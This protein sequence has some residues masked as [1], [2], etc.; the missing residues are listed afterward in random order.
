M[1]VLVLPPSISFVPSIS[2]VS[3]LSSLIILLFLLLFLAFFYSVNG[4]QSFL[5][6]H[7]LL[8]FL[9]CLDHCL[10]GILCQGCHKISGLQPC[11]E[12]REMYLIICLVYF[13]HSSDETRYIRPQWFLLPLFD[14]EQVV[15]SPFWTLPAYEMKDKGTAQ[16]L[17][18][19]NG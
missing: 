10:G 12:G 6:V 15:G 18:V 13:Q 9:Q 4:C 7:I 3:F 1:W 5:S 8:Y 17:E 11:L 2:L 16:L 14:G 19:I